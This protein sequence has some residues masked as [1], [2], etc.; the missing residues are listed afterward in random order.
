MSEALLDLVNA[1]LL[2]LITRLGF[3]VVHSET[4]PSFDNANVVLEG[5]ALRLRVV[6][7][8]GQ[9]FL[10]IGPRSE[11]G[12]WFDSALLMDYLGLSS[13]ASFSYDDARQTLRGAGAFVT[14]MSDELIA[15]FS[16]QQ[17]AAT[18]KELRSRAEARAEKMF[19]W[20]P[21]ARKSNE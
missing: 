13:S 8:R 17:L 10:V 12:T 14:A 5:A 7:E 4:A 16:S 15:A 1:E 6:R 21:P 18:K 3:V 11:P 20:S 2:P 19:G 9:V